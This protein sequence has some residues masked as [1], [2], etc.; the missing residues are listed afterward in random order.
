MNAISSPSVTADYRLRK[1]QEAGAHFQFGVF[2]SFQ[3]DFKT[4]FVIFQQKADRPALLDKVFRLSYGQYRIF[5]ETGQDR[6]EEPLLSRSDEQNL[7]ASDVLWLFEMED[8]QW[9]RADRFAAQACVQRPVKWI[10]SNRAVGQ[11]TAGILECFFRPIDEL[12]KMEKE[13]SLYGIFSR[14][15]TR[16]EIS[17]ERWQ[18]DRG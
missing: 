17:S 13:C 18:E 12:R 8:S 15:G 5:S 11:R 2:R 9:A 14:R 6:R 3:V 4:N 16:V 7:T 10:L 1:R